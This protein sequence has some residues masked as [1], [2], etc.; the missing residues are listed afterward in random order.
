MRRQSLGR[1]QWAQRTGEMTALWHTTPGQ[2]GIYGDRGQLVSQSHCEI[3][4]AS[5]SPISQGDIHIYTYT[6]SYIASGSYSVFSTRRWYSTVQIS[7]LERVRVGRLGRSCGKNRPPDVHCQLYIVVAASCK[8]D[9]PTPA[10]SLSQ[11]ICTVNVSK[12]IRYR[13][14]DI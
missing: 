10:T 8:R 14:V 11:E 12:F 2:G 6:H 9:L 13:Y 5:N 1:T 7:Q 3:A 4:P